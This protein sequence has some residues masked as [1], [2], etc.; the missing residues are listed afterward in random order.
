MPHNFGNYS[1]KSAL[2]PASP[3]R[4][5]K[6]AAPVQT[7][8]KTFRW[9]LPPEQTEVPEKVEVAG[10][11]TGWQKYEM[12]RDISG[13]WQLAFENIPGHRTHHYMF[14]ADGKPVEDKQC[15]G[16]AEPHNAQ[17]KSFAISTPR[18]PRVFM[19]FAQTK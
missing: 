16:L 1:V 4:A 18:G 19:L 15:D 5:P 14:F 3:G 6:L 12:V 13:T 17:E 10:T 2:K 9:S 11:F 7:Y 8:P